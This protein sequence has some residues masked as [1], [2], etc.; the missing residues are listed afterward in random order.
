MPAAPTLSAHLRLDRSL[1]APA[2]DR[3]SAVQDDD[4][5]ADL[6][7]SMRAS[8]LLASVMVVADMAILASCS[9][10]QASRS[11]ASGRLA[12]NRSERTTRLF[13]GVNDVQRRPAVHSPKA[14]PFAEG[15]LRLPRA[16]GLGHHTVQSLA[17]RPCRVDRL[18]P[19]DRGFGRRA[20]VRARAGGRTGRRP[21]ARQGPGPPRVVLDRLDRQRCDA[22]A[23]PPTRRSGQSG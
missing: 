8:G 22:A 18:N 6:T 15:R 12:P 7:R 11:R 1:Q 5:F 2:R 17:S 20:A 23:P 10:R 21:P 16:S 19:A 14:S 9:A 13:L 4:G 3:S